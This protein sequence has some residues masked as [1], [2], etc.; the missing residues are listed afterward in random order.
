MA[1]TSQPAEKV[2]C[3]KLWS[4]PCAAA[5][6][7]APLHVKFIGS[8]GTISNSAI[9][10]LSSQF[11]RNSGRATATRTA[12]V[13]SSCSRRFYRRQIVKGKLVLY[14][15]LHL[16]T[17]HPEND[18][19]VLKHRTNSSAPIITEPLRPG[20]TAPSGYDT[21]KHDDII[22]KSLREV[23]ISRKRVLYRIHEPTLAEYTDNSP[24]LVTPVEITTAFSDTSAYRL[25]VD[26]LPGCQPHC[27]PSRPSSHTHWDSIRR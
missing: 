16:L 12:Y 24:R 5:A 10:N 13:C 14:L 3:T 9:M 1:L 25:I 15:L 4:D 11:L 7:Q 20:K 2:S 18:I 22:G 23:V 21:I 27:F 19:V 6:V 26:I 17:H 8:S